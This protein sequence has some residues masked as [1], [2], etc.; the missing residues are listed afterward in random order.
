MEDVLKEYKYKIVKDLL[1][2]NVI[3][4]KIDTMLQMDYVEESVIFVINILWVMDYAK[5]VFL[6][7]PWFNLNVY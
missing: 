2:I 7:I 3:Y 4:V 6:D 5:V 1:I